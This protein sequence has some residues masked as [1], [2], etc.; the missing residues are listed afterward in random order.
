MEEQLE[1]TLCVEVKNTSHFV[2]G[3][4]KCRETP[5]ACR[6]CLKNWIS[7]AC[8]TGDPSQIRMC[9][10]CR[11]EIKDIFAFAKDVFGTEIEYAPLYTSIALFEYA[12]SLVLVYKLFSGEDITALDFFLWLLYLKLCPYVHNM[13]K[14]DVMYIDPYSNSSGALILVSILAYLL[15]LPYTTLLLISVRSIILSSGVLL[16]T[17]INMARR[18]INTIYDRMRNSN[19]SA[20]WRI[21]SY[22]PRI[23]ANTYNVQLI[24][25]IVTNV[26]DMVSEIRFII[27]GGL[28]HTF[29]S[30]FVYMDNNSLLDSELDLFIFLSMAMIFVF[31]LFL[32]V[33]L[34]RKQGFATRSMLY[35]SVT[36]LSVVGRSMR[37]NVY[38]FSEATFAGIGIL[39]SIAK[40]L[41]VVYHRLQNP[42]LYLFGALSEHLIASRVS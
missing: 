24:Y 13:R 40:S 9:M 22:I 32:Y 16:L 5:P 37:P 18:D 6:S 4:C 8:E 12:L 19:T 2:S 38:L 14:A 1:C 41:E 42:H 7:G 20:F 11:S 33:D 10:Y 31:L 35:L 25:V 15:T 39:L 17:A 28:L 23:L 30:A 27:F 29:I 34:M 26:L 21:L 3:Y 36:V